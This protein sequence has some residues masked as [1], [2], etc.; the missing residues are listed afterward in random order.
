MDTWN[1]LKALYPSQ[2]HPVVIECVNNF[3]QCESSSGSDVDNYVIVKKLLDSIFNIW[4][5]QESGYRTSHWM[6]RIFIPKVLPTRSMAYLYKC[7]KVLT[8][9]II[10]LLQA[11]EA[12]IIDNTKQNLLG[13]TDWLTAKLLPAL[14]STVIL[15]S[16]SRRT[17]DHN[18]LSDGSGSLQTS[19]WEECVTR[20]SFKCVSISKTVKT[21][22]DTVTGKITV[23]NY[24]KWNP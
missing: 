6:H 3:I 15:D 21:I 23:H 19:V 20:A 13:R 5:E 16:E 4:W 10:Y 12:W 9:I 22:S 18:W 8:S 1:R 7:Y 11:V 24:R 17:H 14:A 2:F